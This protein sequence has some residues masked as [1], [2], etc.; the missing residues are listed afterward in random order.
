MSAAAAEPAPAVGELV[1]A[2]AERLAC[3]GVAAPRRD[4]RLLLA[5]ALGRDPGWLLGWPEAP[6]DAAARAR[7]H[8]MVDARAARRPVSRILGRRHFWSLSLAVTAQTLDPRPESETV[9]EAVL[10]QV[11][12]RRARLHVLDLGTGSGCLL[13]ALLSELGRARGV[14][15]DRDHGALRLARE[16]ARVLGLGDR[17]AFL[18]ADWAAPLAGTFDIV[19]CNPPYVSDAELAGLEP[20]VARHDP[21]AALRGGGDGLDAYRAV[22]PALPALL[23]PGGVAALEL[24][25][26]QASAVRDLLAASGLHGRAPVCDLAGVPRCVCATHPKA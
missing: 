22:V 2:A 7:F 21:P 12:D 23:A 17:S 5:A 13:L 14:G 15:V 3:A 10:A 16:N 11:P 4:A 20:E 8:A 26:G 1:A 9:V 25:R 19:V 6:V 24:G 18:A